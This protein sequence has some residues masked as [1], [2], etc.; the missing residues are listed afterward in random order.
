MSVNSYTV[1]VYLSRSHFHTE[2]ALQTNTDVSANLESKVE[3]LQRAPYLAGECVHALTLLEADQDVR[4]P[5][6]RLGRD[7]GH[8]VLLG[9]LF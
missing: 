5:F 8:V 2:A 3:L 1:A 6:S 7:V 4:R 9:Q